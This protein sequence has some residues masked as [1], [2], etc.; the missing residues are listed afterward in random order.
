MLARRFTIVFL[1]LT[2]F[3]MLFS[4]LVAETAARRAPGAS[5]RSCPAPSRT[6]CAACCRN[7]A[8][9]CPSSRVVSGA[10]PEEPVE[11]TI[12]TRLSATARK[13][14][15]LLPRAAL[16]VAVLAAPLL[17]MPAAAGATRSR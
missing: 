5:A 11:R 1:L 7:A 13:T 6:G 10:P 9:A 3:S 8:R 4:T 14:L 17:A 12:M 2:L 16:L 15:M